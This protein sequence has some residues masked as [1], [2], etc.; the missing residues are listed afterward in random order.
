MDINRLTEEIEKNLKSGK[1]LRMKDIYKIDSIVENPISI[2]ILKKYS[3]DKKLD[4]K[5]MFNDISNFILSND[6]NQKLEY[7][8]SIYD[9]DGD[10][11]ISKKDLFA[12]LR[13]ICD[14]LMEDE[15]LN[16]IVD[17]TF[18]DLKCEKYIK[19]QDFY[20]LISKN[21]KNLKKFM[22]C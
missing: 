10:G 19:Y 16:C 17:R 1:E 12:L 13:A 8:F 6:L 20:E 3:I 7:L 21:S 2:L 4:Y 11:L 5:R 18:I 15:N 22:K 9:L 14:K